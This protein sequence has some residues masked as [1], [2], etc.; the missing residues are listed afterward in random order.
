MPLRRKDLLHLCGD[1]T[2][3]T[4]GQDQGDPCG[5]G[6]GILEKILP[7]DSEKEAE[8]AGFISAPERNN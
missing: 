1:S 3:E 8:S 4:E 2:A 6:A 5:R 7:E